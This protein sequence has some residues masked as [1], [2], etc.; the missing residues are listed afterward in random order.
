[1]CLGSL[2]ECRSLPHMHEVPSEARK[3]HR[4]PWTRWALMR[5][6]EE[7]SL[8]LAAE[9]CLQ[10]C[11]PAISE[12][13]TDASSPR[14]WEDP[15]AAGKSLPPTPLCYFA[16]S[17]CP[18]EVPFISNTH[19]KHWICISCHNYTVTNKL[20]QTD[21]QEEEGSHSQATLTLS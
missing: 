16:N 18:R 8:H 21:S 3:E 17:L 2:P 4:I 15:L 7:Q 12:Q 20:R 19:C 10:S 11:H 9:P 14:H 13:W 6:L 5:D 1:M